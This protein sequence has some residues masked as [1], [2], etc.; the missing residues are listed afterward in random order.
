[1]ERVRALV[2]VE[3]RE[4]RRGDLGWVG[5]VVESLGVVV[6]GDAGAGEGMDDLTGEGCAEGAGGCAKNDSYKNQ[7]IGLLIDDRGKREKV[8]IR[9][10]NKEGRGV[11]D[12]R[13]RC[14]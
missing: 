8:L 7:R 9:G 12:T 11:A 4:E 1:V 6:K 14:L 13:E 10:F 3:G 5:R 2:L